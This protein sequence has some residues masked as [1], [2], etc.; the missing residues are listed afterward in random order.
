MKDRVKIDTH[1]HLYQVPEK[2]VEDKANYQIWEFGEGAEPC[3]STSLGSVDDLLR[4]MADNDISQV[5]V[6]NLFIGDWERRRFAAALSPSL[7]DRD[8]RAAIEGYEQRIADDLR[9]FNRW[10]CEIG[11]KHPQI[12]P[13]VST[14]L[15]VLSAQESADHVRDLVLNHG[16]KGIKLHAAIHGNFMADERLWPLYGVAQEYNLP[17]ISHAGLDPERKG[18]CEPRAFAE[19]LAAFPDVRFVLAHMGGGGWRQSCEI[20]ERYPNAWFDVSEIIEWTK[21]SLAPSDEDLVDLIRRIGVERVLMG[22]DFPWYD[23]DR[24]IERVEQLPGLTDEE[25][26]LIMGQNALRLLGQC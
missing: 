7:S 12:L 17:I 2:A 13:Y 1:C 26:T 14:D 5:V 23:L 24:T 20:A 10:G 16:A 9:A 11:K 18:Y 8:R 15:T 21:G 3:Y 25:R 19:P 22:S 6:L 4:Q